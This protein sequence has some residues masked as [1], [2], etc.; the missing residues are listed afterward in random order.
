MNDSGYQ[1]YL[2]GGAVRDHFLGKEVK[3]WDFT[4]TATPEEILKVFP[5]GYYNNQFGTVGIALD[6]NQIIE[7]TTMR[8]E[9]GYSDSRHPDEVQWTTDINEDLKRRDFTINAMAIKLVANN[10]QLLTADNVIDPFNGQKDIAEKIIRAVGDPDTRFH[11]DALRLLR[12]VRFATILDFKIH[13]ITFQSIFHNH[14]LIQQISWERIRDE[15]LKILAADDPLKGI[16]LLQQTQLLDKILPEVSSCFGVMQEGPKHD[17]VYDIGHH[18]FQALKFCPSSDPIVRLSALLHDVGKPDTYKIDSTGNVTFYNHEI[19]GARIAKQIATRLKL[20][21]HQIEKIYT[22][23]RW[24]MF[25]V[26][27]HQ[28]DSAVRR[29]IRNIG[30]DNMTDMMAIREADRLGGGTANAT[31]WRLENFK[32]RIKQVL[33]KPFSVTDLKINGKDVMEILNI[34]PSR[35]VG[36]ILDQLFEEV[37]ADKSKND[38]E[39]LIERLKELHLQ[40]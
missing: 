17:R 9:S 1:L 11:E 26:D 2:V 27:E 24:H 31:S 13:D 21:R 32:E 39:I 7:I 10:Q 20:S 4:T 8:K 22:L 18:S 28:T 19:V 29:I 16:E 23:V 25:S 34:P 36:D 38:R 6:N 5:N 40:N 30:L 3:D 37:L 33:I 12:A 15:L 35:Q 14:H